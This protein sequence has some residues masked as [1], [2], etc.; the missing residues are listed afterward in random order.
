MSLSWL[1]DSLLLVSHFSFLIRKV[2]L[3]PLTC[4]MDKWTK[5]YAFIFIYLKYSAK[6]MEA[7]SEYFTQVNYQQK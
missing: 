2:V 6:P 1:W 4:N 3:M 7:S 5:M